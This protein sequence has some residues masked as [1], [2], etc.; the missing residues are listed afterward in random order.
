[1]QQELAPFDPTKKKKKKKV[2]LQDHAES[3]SPELQMEKADDP[4]PAAVND[5]LE[6]AVS[7]MK[8]S[9]KP[10]AFTPRKRKVSGFS[11]GM[12]SRVNPPRTTRQSADRFF[13]FS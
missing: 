7:G 8:N 6:S 3:S 13:F 1:M 4:M 5:G 11:I 2:V 10:V 9:K 12:G